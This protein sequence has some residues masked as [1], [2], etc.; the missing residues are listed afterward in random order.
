MFPDT[1]RLDR[2]ASRR[3]GVPLLREGEPCWGVH[4][5][6]PPGRAVYRAA[7]RTGAE[8]RRAGGHRDGE[9]AA[10][11]R[12]ARGLGAADRDRRGACRSSIP[13]PA[14]SRR[15]SM[16]CSK[17]RC[18]LRGRFRHAM[19]TYDG[20]H[21]A[22][23]R[24]TECRPHSPSCCGITPLIKPAARVCRTARARRGV[25]PYHRLMDSDPIEPATRLRERV[26][27]LGGAGP[28]L[29]CR[30]ARTTTLL[31][32]HH[33]LSPGSSAVH[34]Q[35][36]R[37]VAELR[38]AGGHRD[39]ERAADH[40]DARGIGAADRDRR[41]ACRSSIPRPATSRRCSMRCWKRR[42]R[43]CGAAHRQ[44]ATL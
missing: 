18:A 7:D 17:R 22:R 40:R 16:R 11:H 44:L 4:A 23:S 31:G 25:C 41:G 26:V 27:D 20:E 8:L 36:D 38:G 33:R 14:T 35:A 3:L 19:H 34:R 32:M 29:W 1:I 21:F 37:A 15:C 24:C 6:P 9:R 5:L 13:R 39:G 42:M 28:L 10:D 12:D 30:C 2:S 43:L